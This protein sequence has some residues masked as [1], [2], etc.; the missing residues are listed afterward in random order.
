[1]QDSVKGMY[2]VELTNLHKSVDT[3]LTRWAMVQCNKMC[4]VRLGHGWCKTKEDLGCPL[5]VAKETPVNIQV[6][7]K[8]A[9]PAEATKSFTAYTSYS[10]T[11]V[12]V[13]G[14][15]KVLMTLDAC[16]TKL[17]GVDKFNHSCRL[18]LLLGCSHWS[19]PFLR[20]PQRAPHWA[21]SWSKRVTMLSHWARL[22]QNNWEK[23]LSGRSSRMSNL[24]QKRWKTSPT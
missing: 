13:T 16:V 1:M 4:M 15:Y 8:I 5:V 22:L 7:Q 19:R 23:S 12:A 20:H 10:N 17:A 18:N 24:R 6:L 2:F 21:S 11:L 9:K 14:L 3:E